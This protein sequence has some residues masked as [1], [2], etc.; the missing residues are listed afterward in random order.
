MAKIASDLDKPR[1]YAVLGQ[2][3]ASAFLATK[4]VSLIFG[5]GKVAQ[6]RLERDGLRL[7]GD[8]QRLSEAELTR[9]YGAE[10]GR[11]ARLAHGIDD[12]PVRSDREAKSISAET[13]FERDIADFKSLERRLWRLSE[14]VSAR[15]KTSDLAGSTVTLKL[16]TADFQIRTRARSLSHP[17]QL[18]ATV[19]AAGQDLLGRETDGTRFRLIGIGV[20]GLTVDDGADHAD[21]LDRRT[22]DAEQAVDRLRKKFGDDAIVR[23]LTL[24]QVDDD[25]E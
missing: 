17:T 6:R 23:G 7:I 15:L 12:R 3:E 8:L 18:A 20:S 11:L 14:R 21:L 25:D 9:R 10:G 19:F 24:E 1:G 2:R 13:T 5:V 22:A 4:P 16:K